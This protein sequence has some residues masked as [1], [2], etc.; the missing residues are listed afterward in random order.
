MATTARPRDHV[1]NHSTALG[2]LPL[3]NIQNTKPRVAS[4]EALTRQLNDLHIY[5]SDKENKSAPHVEVRSTST[6][7][8]DAT[9]GHFYASSGHGNS[10]VSRDSESKNHFNCLV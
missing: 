3:S 10:A 8:N 4:I 1:T 6:T 2:E 9:C 5:G 7:A